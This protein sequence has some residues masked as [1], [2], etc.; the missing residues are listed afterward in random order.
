MS[1][2]FQRVVSEE[3]EEEEAGA[4]LKMAGAISSLLTSSFLHE[5]CKD[6]LSPL[7]PILP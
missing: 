6:R 3:E 5:S 2:R 4:C 7:L 1:S